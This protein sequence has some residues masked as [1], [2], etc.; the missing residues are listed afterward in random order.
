MESHAQTRNAWAVTHWQ[1]RERIL[2]RPPLSTALENL[3]K[4]NYQQ[5]SYSVPVHM[6]VPPAPI[7][8]LLLT[9]RFLPRTILVVA[10]LLQPVPVGAFLPLIPLVIILLFPV[11]VAFIVVLVLRV[12]HH[13]GAQSGA[14]Q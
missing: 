9:A 2:H 13:L 6:F 7:F 11:V 3:I 14:Q 4:S 5:P 8:S 12:H 1:L 10:L